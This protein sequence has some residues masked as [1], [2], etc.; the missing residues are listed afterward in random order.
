V[1][2]SLKD[3]SMKNL[4]SSRVALYALLL[5]TVVVCR[6]AYSNSCTSAKRG[7]I[8]KVH[9]NNDEKWVTFTLEGYPDDWM[10]ISPSQGVDKP[11]G[12]VMASI[13]LTAYNKGSEIDVGYCTGDGRID[14]LIIRNQ[15]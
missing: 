5:L 8:D 9:Y 15:P 4:K 3:E 1:L 12:L 14:R 13:L 11:Y 6:E 7:T 2:V 10:S